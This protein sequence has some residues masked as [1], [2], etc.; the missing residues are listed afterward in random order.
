VKDS[1]LKDKRILAV[2]DEPDV[3]DVLKEEITMAVPTCVVDSATSYDKATELIASCTY[4]LAI[5]DIMGVRGFDLLRIAVDRKYPIP[6]V[7][8]TAHALSPEFLKESI[9]K[10]AR[11]Y[12][13]KSSLGNVV[14]F[15]KD[16]LT[17]EY[18]AVWRRVLKNIEGVFSNSRGPYWRKPD[19][20]F[21]IKFEEKIGQK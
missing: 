21:W 18:G 14:P 2:D 6:V 13:P 11:A 3:L 1:V 19:E 10:G 8:L 16:V 17:Y 5:F 7:M 12:L 20:E 15:L 4:D 9:E